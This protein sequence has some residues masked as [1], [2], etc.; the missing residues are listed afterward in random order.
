LWEVTS[1]LWEVTY[2]TAA[3]ATAPPPSCRQRRAVALPQPPLTLPPPPPSYVALSHCR[4]AA[5]QPTMLTRSNLIGIPRVID[6]NDPTDVQ[7]FLDRFE[8]YRNT[9]DKRKLPDDIRFYGR[10]SFAQD[11]LKGRTEFASFEKVSHQI[12]GTQAHVPDTYAPTFGHVIF[13]VG[14]HYP[15]TSK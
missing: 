5:N 7:F 9:T 15:L 3:T 2:A 4:A 13:I 10:A 14:F 12:P 11:A 1:T 8:K 6:H